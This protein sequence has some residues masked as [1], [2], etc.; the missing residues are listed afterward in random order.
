MRLVAAFGLLL[1]PGFGAAPSTDLAPVLPTV[2][3]W[4]A[5]WIS[6]PGASPAGY[7]VYHFRRRFRVD[8]V[9]AAFVVHVSADNRYEL[10]ANGARVA[11]G[12]ASATRGDRARTSSCC[13]PCSASIPPRRASGACASVPSSAGSPAFPARYRIQEERSS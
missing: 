11:S 3:P 2:R 9:P 4:T 5:R 13:G 12:R 10:Y 1:L 8:P 7:G 6:V